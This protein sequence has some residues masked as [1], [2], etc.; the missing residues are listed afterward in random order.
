LV[1]VE[2]EKDLRYKPLI[3][4]GIEYAIIEQFIVRIGY[5]TLPSTSGSQNFNIS[6]LYSFGMGLFLKKFEIDIS[7]S[8]H[9]TLGWSPQVSLQYKFK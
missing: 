1:A 4:A 5:S 6:S 8:I 7:S 9:Q 3:R 2:T